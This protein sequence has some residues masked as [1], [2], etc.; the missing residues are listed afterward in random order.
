MSFSGSKKE[1]LRVL[2]NID[3]NH[4]DDCVNS[5]SKK[6]LRSF[7]NK[8]KVL[9]C[10]N[11][12]SAAEAE[13]FAAELVCKFKKVRQALPALA[14]H[15]NI[16]TITAISNDFNFEDIFNLE[17]LIRE[18]LNVNRNEQQR[19]GVSLAGM[20]ISKILLNKNND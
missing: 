19:N 9:I 4:I 3:S 18:K 8:G 15:S 2:N 13:H 6:I 20:E 7:S 11:G 17:N 14:L 5:L 12:G 1:I 16:P 10:G